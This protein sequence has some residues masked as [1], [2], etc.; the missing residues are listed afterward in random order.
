ML[1]YPREC[2]ARRQKLAAGA[3]A[4]RQVRLMYIRS[5]KAMVG[6]IDSE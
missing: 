1:G 6:Y 2:S 3:D 4:P 5:G